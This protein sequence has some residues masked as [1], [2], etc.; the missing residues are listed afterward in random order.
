MRVTTV[1]FLFLF[2]LSACGLIPRP[3]QK[4]QTPFEE[5]VWASRSGSAS[6][7]GQ[8]FLRT[9]GGSVRTCAGKRVFLIPRTPYTE[10]LY[11]AKSNGSRVEIDPRMGRFIRMDVCNT[12]GDYSFNGV[13]GGQWFIE[14]T[15][16]WDA[17]GRSS[18]LQGGSLVGRVETTEGRAVKFFLTGEHLDGF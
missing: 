16:M 7:T 18:T 8:G 10:E 5:P 14:T 12:Q 17:G 13:P 2:L 15:V 6:I 9:R 4:I 1:A 3:I 11:R